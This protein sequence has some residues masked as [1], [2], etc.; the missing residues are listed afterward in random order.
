MDRFQSINENEFIELEDEIEQ[1]NP[2]QQINE[3]V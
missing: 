2:D 3:F 1:S